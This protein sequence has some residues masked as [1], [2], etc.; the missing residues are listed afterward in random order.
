MPART[1]P[2]DA[3]LK[4]SLYRVSDAEIIAKDRPWARADLTA[5]AG[6]PGGIIYL[7]QLPDQVIAFDANTKKRKDLAPLI[8]LDDD[9]SP[10][11]TGTIQ[12][13]FAT[14]DLSAEV[15][16]GRARDA[17][18]ADLEKEARKV[19]KKLKDGLNITDSEVLDTL[20]YILSRDG[21]DE[22]A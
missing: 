4:W 3:N 2:I 12:R 7:Q 15:I 17:M 21:L 22:D 5:I 18:I 10:P 16:A 13:R 8:T 19:G 20:K 9:V 11:A 1:Y 6:D 14:E